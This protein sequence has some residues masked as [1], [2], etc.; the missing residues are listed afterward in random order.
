MKKK[1]LPTLEQFFLAVSELFQITIRDILKP[2]VYFYYEKTLQEAYDA[3]SKV[4]GASTVLGM[5][6]Q[7]QHYRLGGSLDELKPLLIQLLSNA[8]QVME[9]P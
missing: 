3:I 4:E 7:Y 1:L 6:L 5:K 9:A 2:D 8:D